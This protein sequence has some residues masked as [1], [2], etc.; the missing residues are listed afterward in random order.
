MTLPSLSH[1][2]PVVFRVPHL[3]QAEVVLAGI[4]AALGVAPE[5]RLADRA[6][7]EIEDEGPGNEV[8]VADAGRASLHVSGEYDAVGVGICVCDV[9]GAGGEA[10]ARADAR[11]PVRVGK[12]RVAEVL[13]KLVPTPLGSGEASERRLV[14]DG[15]R[16]G[17]AEHARSEHESPRGALHPADCCSARRD[18]DFFHLG[19]GVLG[20]GKFQV[21]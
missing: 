2:G 7:S 15:H 18:A 11:Q 17:C 19:S 20:F 21:T 1:P 13:R 14:G 16:R 4:H 8:D 10:Q 6:I 3:D 5:R 9:E 12:G